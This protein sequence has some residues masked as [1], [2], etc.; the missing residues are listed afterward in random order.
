MRLA[1]I[2]GTVTSTV[3]DPQLTGKPMLLT[4]VVDGAGKIVE[5]A[6]VAID[7]VGAG[8]GDTVLLSQGSAARLPAGTASAPI[9]TTIIAIVEHV[10]VAKS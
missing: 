2:I 5:Q 3:K 7:T 1:K 10:T 6:I 8:V 4:N 9:D